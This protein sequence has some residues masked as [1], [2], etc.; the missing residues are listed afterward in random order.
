MTEKLNPKHIRA[1]KDGKPPMEYLVWE[2]LVAVARVLQHGALKYG[3]RNWLKDAILCTTYIAAFFRHI[4]LGWALGEDIDPDSGEHHL[5]HVA[6]MCLIIMDAQKH[7]TLIDDRKRCE[8]IDQ[9]DVNPLPT[10]GLGH[11]LHLGD[12]DDD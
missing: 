6:A 3:V 7:G 1:M 10:L 8:S 2:P 11:Y 5:A 9:G 12:E 4:F